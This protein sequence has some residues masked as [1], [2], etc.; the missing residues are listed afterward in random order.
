MGS[1]SWSDDT[2]CLYCDGRLPLYR[3]ITHG[4]FCSSGHRKSYWQD[5][6]RLAVERLS[7]T[8]NSLRAIRQSSPADFIPG[9]L[10]ASAQV[11][12]SEPGDP[13]FGG[14]VP[15]P[16]NPVVGASPNLVAADPLEYEM[17]SQPQ[18]PSQRISEIEPRTLPLADQIHDWADFSVCQW[19]GELALRGLAPAA[20][21]M[22]P[23]LSNL[24]AV[25]GEGLA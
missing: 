4:Q 13:N 24:A 25:F 20:W 23:E 3:K 1:M 9:A 5:Q 10:P 6:E 7:Q 11:I 22:A 15:Q 16:V 12:A 19:N 8:H 2:R 18:R 21:K 14:L 17:A